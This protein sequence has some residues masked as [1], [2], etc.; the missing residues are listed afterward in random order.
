[1]TCVIETITQ[2]TLLLIYKYEYQRKNI[3]YIIP[4]YGINYLLN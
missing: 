1:M 2:K 3:Y 4:F